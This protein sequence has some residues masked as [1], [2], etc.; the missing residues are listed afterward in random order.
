MH[1]KL[2][3]ICSD[4]TLQLACAYSTCRFVLNL[5]IF[6]ANM[7]C[8]HEKKWK[9]RNEDIE[10]DKPPFISLHSFARSTATTSDFICDHNFYYD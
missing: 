8:V 5:F 6:T 9:K 7:L 3:A 10:V 4:S 1:A 2:N